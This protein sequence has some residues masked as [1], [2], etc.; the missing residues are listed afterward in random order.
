[1]GKKNVYD[2]SGKN[3]LTTPIGNYYETSH[4]RPHVANK[5]MELIYR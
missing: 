2:F 4:Y 5:I 3:K 1:L